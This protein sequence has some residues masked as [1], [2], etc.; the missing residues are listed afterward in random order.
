MPRAASPPRWLPAYHLPAR[1]IRYAASGGLGGWVHLLGSSAGAYH[2]SPSPLPSVLPSARLAPPEVRDHVYRATLAAHPLLECHEKELLSRGL[3]LGEIEAIGFRSW[4]WDKYQR[5]AV[6]AQVYAIHRE[7]VDVPGFILRQQNRGDYVSLGGDVGIA[8]PVL[9][10]AGQIVGLQILRDNRS[11]GQGKYRWL[12]STRYGGPSPGTPIHIARPR[13]G[14]RSKRVWLTEGA[15]KADIAAE[16]L[17]EVVL[18][19][20]G[21]HALRDLPQTLLDLVAR[22]S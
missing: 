14:S 17:G 11:D 15:L 19:I 3:S 20:P 13:S 1:S 9:N 21:V 5:R 8:I 7:A 22:G 12:S 10:V 16:R 6:A 2:P 4:G 18:A